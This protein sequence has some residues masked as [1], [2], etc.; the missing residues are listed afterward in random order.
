MRADP[1]AFIIPF[2]R[3]KVVTSFKSV[4]WLNLAGF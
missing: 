2:A 1:G 4:A 3:E